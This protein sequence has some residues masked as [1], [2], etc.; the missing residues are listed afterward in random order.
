MKREKQRA[1][2]L[3]ALA[4]ALL[5]GAAGLFFAL[6]PEEEHPL[7][8]GNRIENGDFSAVTNGMPD[9]W[10]TGMWVTS[11]GGS[12]LEAVTL[13]AV[14]YTHLDVYKRQGSCPADGS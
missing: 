3:A 12:V 7:Q 14:S 4:L 8:E 10:E 1:V 11:Y 6:R 9:G 2:W 5:V 13:E